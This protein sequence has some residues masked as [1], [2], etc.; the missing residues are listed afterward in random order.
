MKNKKL[1]KKFIFKRFKTP[2]FRWWQMQ[3][4]DDDFYDEFIRTI[5]ENKK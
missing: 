4:L 1:K 2:F 5:L 3:K